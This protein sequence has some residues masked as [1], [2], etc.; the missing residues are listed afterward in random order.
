[1]PSRIN[2]VAPRIESDTL[3]KAQRAI[4]TAIAQRTASGRDST[5]VQ[6]SLLSGYSSTSSSFHNALGA[7]RSA[8]LVVGSGAELRVTAQGL[9]AAGHVPPLPSG[10]ELRVHWLAHRALGKAERALLG[11]MLAHPRGLDRADLSRA[12]GYS[13]TSSSFH[14]ALGRLRSLELVRSVGP[15]VN[16]AHADFFA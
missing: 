6:A 13:E 12:S 9:A 4:L 2:A 15:G 7:L 10:A 5:A 8:G 16:A 11:A 3:P 1:M 14:N